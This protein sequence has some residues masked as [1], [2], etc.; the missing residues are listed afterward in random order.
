[1]D[2]LYRLQVIS[3]KS[4]AVKYLDKSLLC[5]IVQIKCGPEPGF[6]VV[7]GS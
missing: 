6:V 4:E 5:F 2:P 1:M 7:R 3:G